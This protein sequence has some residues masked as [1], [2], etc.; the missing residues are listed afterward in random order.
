MYVLQQLPQCI[1]YRAVTS[2]QATLS[3][4]SVQRLWVTLIE[5]VGKSIP[6]DQDASEKIWTQ[7]N[8]AQ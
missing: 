6:S 7:A 3:S 8:P 1:G 2:Q 4:E 5:A